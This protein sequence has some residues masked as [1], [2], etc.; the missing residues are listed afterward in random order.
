M[1][2]AELRTRLSDKALFHEFTS[3]ELDEF[4]DLLD[5]VSVQAGEAIVR[6][7][8]P[9]DS[10]YIVVCGECRVVHHKNGHDLELARLKDG[11]FFG[12]LALVDSGARSADVIAI[13][14]VALFKITQ[15]MIAALAGVYPGAA[16]KL[17]IAIGR[18]MVERLRHANQRYVDSL[19]FPLQ[20]PD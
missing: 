4:F 2:I 9:G 15:A 6:Q 7:D 18:I 14:D 17:L 16:F 11:D 12:E 13:T 5:P 3:Q 10:M 1:T 20:G 19:L 8:E